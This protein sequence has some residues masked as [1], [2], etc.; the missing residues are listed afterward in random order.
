MR[1]CSGANDQS[2]VALA[3]DALPLFE[4]EAKKRQVRTVENRN[5]VSEK[6]HTQEPISGSKKSKTK[7]SNANRSSQKAAKKLNT[8]RQYLSDAKK[9]KAEKPELFEK[10]KAGEIKLVQA[11]RVIKEEKQEVTR[12]ENKYGKNSG[13]DYSARQESRRGSKE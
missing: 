6:I 1:S 5:L 13:I 10:I 7:S 12:Q 2:L 4:A 3:V 11:K 8:N 9:M